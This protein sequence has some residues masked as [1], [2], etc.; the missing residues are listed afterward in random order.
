[1]VGVKFKLLANGRAVEAYALL[2]QGANSSLIKDDLVKA[3]HPKGTNSPVEF[4]NVFR[5]DTIYTRETSFN[6][7][8]AGGDS[9]AVSAY[10]TPH[11]NMDLKTLDWD[12]AKETWSQ[13]ED[14]SPL[15]PG[16][17]TVVIVEISLHFPFCFR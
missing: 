13:L 10:T 7:R 3:L 9:L 6:V 5:K 8:V 4:H 16:Y 17:C 15:V 12:R 1:M 11:I 2:D 14:I